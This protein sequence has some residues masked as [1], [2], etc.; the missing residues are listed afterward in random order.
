MGVVSFICSALEQKEWSSEW[1][2][3][4]LKWW[5]RVLQEFMKPRACVVTEYFHAVC[6]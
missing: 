4:R 6:R 3:M 1:R 5:K 2:K